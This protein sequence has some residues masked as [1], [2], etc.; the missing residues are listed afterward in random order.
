MLTLTGNN[1]YSGD[2]EIDVGATLRVDGTIAS[3]VTLS[4]GTLSGDGTVGAVT[5]TSGDVAPGDGATPGIL[6][7]GALSLPGGTSY[8]VTAIG[9][10]TAGNG[11]GFYAQD[12][13]ASG[14]I[15]LGGTLNLPTSSSYT[16]QANDVYI[17][18][19]NATAN[20]AITG[21]FVAG[22][23][24]TAVSPE[25]TLAE[26]T[27]LS[28]NFLNSG[29]TARITYLAGTNG[30]SVAIVIG[31]LRVSPPANTV[32]ENGSVTGNVLTGASDPE[33][34]IISVTAGTFSTAHGSII[35]DA[36]GSYTYTPAVGYDD[37]DSYSFTAMTADGDDSTPSTV[38]FT[39]TE[40]NDLTVAPPAN[41]VAENG[42]VRG[43]V[44]TGA[45]DP[46]ASIISVT[47]GM[48]STAHGSITIDASGNYTYTAAVGYDG[49]DSY[50][51]TA[52]TADGEDSATGTVNFT[53]TEV[54]DLVAGT[55][56]NTTSEGMAVTGSVLTGASDSE[57]HAITATAG[58]F[59]TAHGGSV[60]IAAGG[61]YT[62]TPAAGFQGADSFGFT[63]Q[64]TDGNSS[65]LESR[66]GTVTMTVADVAPTVTVSTSPPA[67]LPEN[68]TPSASGTFSD[69]DDNVT[70]L[71]T[72]EG[73]ITPT[74]LGT[75]S[76][77]WTWSETAPLADGTHTVTITARNALGTI[78]RTSFKFTATEVPP[79]LTQ[80][81]AT[82]TVNE[83]ATAS[84]S[85]TWSDYDGSVTLRASQ[86]TV[87]KNSNGTWSWSQTAD[88][89]AGGNV[90]ITATNSG[91]GT[92]SVTFSVT[93]TDLQLTTLATGTLPTGKLEGAAIG[94]ITG[95]ATF[96][97]PGGAE[98]TSGYT[99]T[100][101]W[102]DSTTSTGTV[103]L[104]SGNNFRVNAPSHTYAEEGTYTVNVT[105]KHDALAAVTTPNGTITIADAR[106]TGYSKTLSA[107]HGVPLTNVVVASFTDADPGGTSTDYTA[108]IKWGD[109]SANTAGTVVFNASTGRFDVQGGHTYAAHGTYT[110]TIT[111]TDSGGSTITI[112]DTITVADARDYNAL[113]DE[114]LLD[115]LQ[116]VD[117]APMAEQVAS[118]LVQQ[119]SEHLTGLPAESSSACRIADALFSRPA[120]SGNGLFDP[121][122]IMWHRTAEAESDAPR[123]PRE[124]AVVR[125][126][127]RQTPEEEK[128]AASAL[129]FGFL[130]AMAGSDGLPRENSGRRTRVAGE[131]LPNLEGR[132]RRRRSNSGS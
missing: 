15:T 76:G 128:T 52:L 36:S 7:T 123:Y 3:N 86:G 71:T 94:S 127:P 82:V 65:A 131:D 125:I 102:G 40:V 55:P 107:T 118:A 117:S 12:D 44:L 83:N 72:S 130:I 30:D 77:T 1:T 95:I 2:T 114:E 47:A 98:S 79:T 16:P 13:V 29:L 31:D 5:G 81:F 122:C 92:A 24:I 59:T 63:I 22:A 34:S 11:S 27:I 80:A 9:G 97:D 109:G 112:T 101:N 111:V 88:D 54:N 78:G 20:N 113:L 19:N 75:K 45:T 99:A 119:H 50:S 120:F 28:T 35:I 68:T 110:I 90:T 105:L 57:G 8:T 91:G 129:G 96:T 39:I 73:T 103:V 74:G 100:I 115:I 48:F 93:F 104:V 116:E 21:N 106:L 62:Y 23:G 69:F 53:V 108:T 37:A 6:T 132:S 38:N 41:T 87:V 67:S 56:A 14:T 32:A 64:T 66:T 58:T 85:G 51:F 42:S 126:E 124:L 25:T 84:N 121:D 17:I 4:G 18:I 61:S 43:D 60:S 49:A 70:S 46:E 26:G 89:T 10:N 33:G